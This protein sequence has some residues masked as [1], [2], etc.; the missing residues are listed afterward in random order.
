MSSW[1][2]YAVIFKSKVEHDVKNKLEDLGLD[3]YHERDNALK[4][5]DFGG[6]NVSRDQVEK[7]LHSQLED[8]DGYIHVDA[9]DNSDTAYATAY[10]NENGSLES[11]QNGRS[12]G[13]S[14]R[15]E[16]YGIRHQGVGLDGGKY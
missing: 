7:V 2:N 1:N 13:E 15:R 11:V 10:S 14:T 5:T 12:G 8:I 16:W 6:N 9:N 3:T 4:L